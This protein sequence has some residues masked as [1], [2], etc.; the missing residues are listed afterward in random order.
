M[1]DMAI[2][3]LNNTFGAT[4]GFFGVSESLMLKHWDPECEK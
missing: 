2:N 4:M 3:Q 1:E